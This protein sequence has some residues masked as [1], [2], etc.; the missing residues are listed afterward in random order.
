MRP[1]ATSGWQVGG[2]AVS[3]LGRW[4]WLGDRRELMSFIR[5][6]SRGMSFMRY[7]DI[8]AV[9]IGR[10]PLPTRDNMLASSSEG[11]SDMI[12]LVYL[13]PGFGWWRGWALRGSLGNFVRHHRVVVESKSERLSL[14]IS[15][16]NVLYFQSAIN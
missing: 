8:V 4:V 6:V 14:S 11:I 3:R 13:L 1:K 16:S 10:S 5:G 15:R 2:C 9:D 7:V 12:V